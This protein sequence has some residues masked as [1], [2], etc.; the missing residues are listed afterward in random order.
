MM[1]EVV[2][3]F[4]PT[5]TLF[6]ANND[7]VQALL[8]HSSL[9]N[10]TGDWRGECGADSL[11]DHRGLRDVFHLDWPD[12]LYPRIPQT[13]R[14]HWLLPPAYSCWLHW[15]SWGFPHSNWVR[16]LSRAYV[17]G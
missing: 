5:Q 7:E 2:V 16:T 9:R 10:R 1:I 6:V 13:R 15:W 11:D 17:G 4:F 12:F 14:H 3:S 8:S